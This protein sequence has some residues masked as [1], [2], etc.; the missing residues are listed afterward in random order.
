MGFKAHWDMLIGSV[1]VRLSEPV[2]NF[3]KILS[4]PN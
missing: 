2:K 3:C 1:K 4:E